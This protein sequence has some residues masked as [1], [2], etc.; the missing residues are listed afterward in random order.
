MERGLQVL[1]AFHADRS[2]LTNLE[3]SRR[4][5]LSKA[6]V[7]R[8]TTTLLRL[9][10]LRREPGGARFALAT[11]ALGI[12]HTYIETNPVTRLV[13]PLLQDLADRLDVS[14][15]LAMPDQLDMLYIAQGVGA[16]IGTLRIGIGSLIPMGWTA[17]GRAWLWGLPPDVRRAYIERLMQAAGPRAGELEHGLHA[18]FADLERNG[19]YLSLGNFQ[20]NAFAIALPVKVGQAG[21]LMALSCGA[22]E[23]APD[24]PALRRRIA[25]ALKE[26]AGEVVALLRDTDSP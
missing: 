15:A 1:R 23:L 6:T 20:R 3:L 14:A 7:S 19:V 17:S 5:G 9:G 16:K 13:Q 4:T 18:A 21:T 25:P 10:F 8:M 12:G 11:A 24:I 2:P 26:A 22:I